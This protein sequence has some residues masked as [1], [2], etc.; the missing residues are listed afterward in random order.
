MNFAACLLIPIYNHWRSIRATVER[1]DQY[2]LP[3]LVIDDGSDET[4]RQVL[5][6]L[7]TDFPRLR[8]FRL[9]QNGGKGA[10][11]KRG[12]REALAASFTHALQIDADGQHDTN[13]V[14]RFLELG[15]ANP[16][17]LICGRPIY[18]DSIPKS[19][20]YGRYVTHFWVCVETL[21]VSVT[22]AMCGF[23][24]YPLA[25][26]CALISRVQLPSR[27]HI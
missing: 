12:M 20:L 18:D 14:P 16:S 24:L 10:A 21:N 6:T 23:R 7:T 19:R 9:P 3:I 13:D 25:A 1:L 8:L 11:V 26:S 27:L 15:A 17:A 2:A 5:A 4:T 22:D